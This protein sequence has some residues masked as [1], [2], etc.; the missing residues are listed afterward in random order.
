MKR[1][2][3]LL[4]LAAVLALAAQPALAWKHK[5]HPW[6][7]TIEGSGEMVEVARDL[8]DFDKIE[9]KTCLDMIVE[10]GP[11]T[12]A[13]LTIDDN[14]ADI[15]KTEVK[16][17][18]LILDFE[19]SCSS[20]S[21]C[22]VRLTVPQLESVRVYGS[23]DAEVAGLR[24]EEFSLHIYGSGDA[25]LAGETGTFRLKIFGSGD[26]RAKDLRA[27]AAKVSIMGSGDVVLTAEQEIGASIFGSGDIVCYG[28]P[29]E[30]SKRALGSGHIAYK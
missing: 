16:R 15:I 4:L 19:E 21:R 3:A 30:R 9:N 29:E 25:V 2:P 11:K 23:G 17:G 12:S 28:D 18:K 27:D 22:M 5:K 26:V 6:S 10:V 1:L 8:D 24:G 20:R 13:V 14:L 7:K